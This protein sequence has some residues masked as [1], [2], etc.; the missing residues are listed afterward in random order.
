MRNRLKKP[1]MLIALVMGAFL[2]MGV[3][4]ESVTAMPMFARKYG[5]SCNT[6]HIAIPRLNAFGRAYKKNSFFWPG[7]GAEGDDAAAKVKKF[8]LGN[9]HFGKR[10]T[11]S[12]SVPIG[13][14]GHFEL[15]YYPDANSTAST[16]DRISKFDMGVS[17]FEMF[18][19]GTL[20]DTFSYLVIIADWA[21]EAAEL[22]IHGLVGHALNLR[23]GVLPSGPANIDPGYDGMS[24]P[25]SNGRSIQPRGRHSS[26][27]TNRVGAIEVYGQGKMWAYGVGVSNGSEANRGY[28][29]E[30]QTSGTGNSGKTLWLWL[31]F[32]LGGMAL[33]GTGG[34][35]HA[36]SWRDDHFRIHPYILY[37]GDDGV[38]TASY[39][40]TVY[41]AEL[42]L[43]YNIIEFK[44]DAQSVAWKAKVGTYDENAFIVGANLDFLLMN[45]TIIP[46]I[47]L[48]TDLNND[49]KNRTSTITGENTTNTGKKPMWLNIHTAIQLRANVK[50]AAEAQFKLHSTAATEN[51][52]KSRSFDNFKI[53]I[54][55]G[56]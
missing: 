3:V 49:A 28:L 40:K 45:G 26:P 52:L 21:V 30:S 33:D 54:M 11:L 24:S 55:W 56:W 35:K 14:V 43:W 27:G 31:D 15:Q 32:Q 22:K 19:G 41:G 2:I 42:E 1:A 44:I 34:A 23:A 9:A 5:T 37:A 36:Q 13:F 46:G 6:C 16:T 4:A 17:A 39:S 18:T 10:A 8:E 12:E 20:G 48:F 53:D 7:G 47:S 50:I 51:T 29:F 25:S 38:A